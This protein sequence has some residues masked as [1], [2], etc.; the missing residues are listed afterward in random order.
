MK[1]PKKNYGWALYPKAYADRIP[2]PSGAW[3][4][5]VGEWILEYLVAP[6]FSE[7][8]LAGWREDRYFLLD[9][10]VFNWDELEGA[11]AGEGHLALAA[12]LQEKTGRFFQALEGTF[13]GLVYDRTKEELLLY[14]NATGDRPVYYLEDEDGLWAGQDYNR[15]IEILRRAGKALPP[16]PLAFRSMVV[17]GS[18]QDDRTW[19]EG[20][21][22]LTAGMCLEKRGKGPAKSFRYH[23][24]DTSRPTLERSEAEW[25]EALDASFRR[26]LKRQ[27]DLDQKYGLT[28]LLDLSGGL[29]SRMLVAVAHAMGY[30]KAILLSYASMGSDEEEIAQEVALGTRYPFFFMGLDDGNFLLDLEGLVRS[31]FGAAYYIGI[32][33]GKRLLS[34]LNGEGFGMEHTG[35]LGDIADGGYLDGPDGNYYR[36]NQHIQPGP[37]FFQAKVHYPNFE[38][39]YFYTR[40]CLW[41]LSSMLT[42]RK[43]GESFSPF[44]QKEFLELSHQIPVALRHPNGI[45]R[46][47]LVEKYPQAADIPYANGMV[48]ISW[49]WWRQKLHKAFTYR[50]KGLRRR[51]NAV[52]F[53]KS[54]WRDSRSMNPVQRYYDQYAD[55]RAGL[56]EER[57]AG[58]AR[59]QGMEELSDIYEYFSDDS[60]P[61]YELAAFLTGAK[62]Y[63]LYTDAEKGAL[64]C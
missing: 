51:F 50:L 53:P 1:D 61:Y 20:I 40:G 38:T 2:T 36:L 46:K 21:K 27:L 16:D 7:E 18:M 43:Y 44:M 24:F 34:T 48:K 10:L 30:S 14:T 17:F 56:D 25:I 54:R 57:R 3:R 42:R 47:W 35:L 12:R 29:D 33:G 45:F 63:E 37:D 26:C 32:T 15:L 31:N 13:C 64:G 62:A 19:V 39:F 28:S 22:R 55:L 49:P 8:K 11:K 58:L 5:E 6:T 4:M 23:S 60:R 59:I 52:F 9:G 41:G